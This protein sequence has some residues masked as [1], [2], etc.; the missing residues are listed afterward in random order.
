MDCFLA[1]KLWREFTKYRHFVTGR[2]IAVILKN[3]Q[4]VYC[5]VWADMG[6]VHW[7]VLV[8]KT[9]LVSLFVTVP[10]SI[11]V[12]SEEEAPSEWKLWKR[13]N[14]VDYEEEVSH[15][16][17]INSFLTCLIDCVVFFTSQFCMISISAYTCYKI[18]STSGS[19]VSFHFCRTQN[20]K[21]IYCTNIYYI[22]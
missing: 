12:E 22:L 3:P 14:R 11:A 20:W 19:R 15:L 4:A 7:M 1:W 16:K 9:L 17:Q 2:Y 10:L 18:Y 8:S 5:S 6:Q 13:A 21:Q